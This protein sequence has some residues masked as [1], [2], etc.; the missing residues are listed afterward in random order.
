MSTHNLSAEDKYLI[1]IGA[2]IE[3]AKRGGQGLYS[4]VANEDAFFEEDSQRLFGVSWEELKKAGK[5]I[6]DKASPKLHKVC[7]DTDSDDHIKIAN[8]IKSGS[9]EIAAGLAALIVPY[10][11]AL[12]SVP[13]AAVGATAYFLGKLILEI[14]FSAAYES[15]CEKWEKSLTTQTAS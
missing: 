8:M 4:Y 13:P 6:W 12:A 2:S 14:F 3:D 10:L 15:G 5:E 1:L 11:L 7:C 9:K